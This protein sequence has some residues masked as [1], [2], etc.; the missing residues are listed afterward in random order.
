MLPIC[1]FW[2]LRRNLCNQALKRK[3]RFN[4]FG[5]IHPKENNQFKIKILLAT[6]KKGMKAAKHN[7]SSSAVDK[8]N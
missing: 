8:I 6:K 2:F 5:L 7:T 4:N 1:I 3:K